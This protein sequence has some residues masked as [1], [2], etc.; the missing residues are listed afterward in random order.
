MNYNSNAMKSFFSL[1]FFI[2]LL[3][4]FLPP[5]FAS[6]TAGVP[7]LI[8]FQGRLMNSSGT[9]LGSAS[10]TDYCYK[11]SIWDAATAG[12]KI[13]P[14]GAPNINTIVTRQ[15]VFDASIGSVDTLDLAF[16]DDQAYV[17]VSVATKVGASCTTGGG[18]VFEDLSPR[19]RIVSSA[20]AINSK[21]VGGF[22]PAQSATDNQIPVLTTGALIL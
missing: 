1:F 19:P 10:G 11:F 8:N 22:T 18:E 2:F 15:G 21:T 5:N 20:F 9:L 6:A 17:E 14:A 7:L 4:V 12:S 3:S 13:W 16:T